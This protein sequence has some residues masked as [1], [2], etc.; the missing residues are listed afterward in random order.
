MNWDPRHALIVNWNIFDFHL[1]MIS[2]SITSGYHLHWF[3][4]E[5]G[6]QANLLLV[7]TTFEHFI[8]YLSKSF[9]ITVS[10][11]HFSSLASFNLSWDFYPPFLWKMSYSFTIRSHLIMEAKCS[12]LIIDYELLPLSIPVLDVL[13][14]CNGFELNGSIWKRWFFA[15]FMNFEKVGKLKILGNDRVKPWPSRVVYKLMIISLFNLQSISVWWSGSLIRSTKRHQG[16]CAFIA[17]YSTGISKSNSNNR[18]YSIVEKKLTNG[19][20]SD[21]SCIQKALDSKFVK[22]FQPGH[23][24]VEQHSKINVFNSKMIVETF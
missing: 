17:R 8:T 21:E 24:V 22:C 4:C 6:N 3:S 1:R 5:T 13:Y 20:P 16:L 10:S 18:F 12:S 23:S 7:D 14:L 19:L 2:N 9:F 11:S 15:C